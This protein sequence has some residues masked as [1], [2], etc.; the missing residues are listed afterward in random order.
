MKLCI[1]RQENVQMGENPPAPQRMQYDGQPS[2]RGPPQQPGQHHPP[3]YQGQSSLQGQ[4]TNSS[5]YQGR[6]NN[7]NDSGG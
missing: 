3:T 4:P 1:F 7:S 6:Q 2:T 5:Q